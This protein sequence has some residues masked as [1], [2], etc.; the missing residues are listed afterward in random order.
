V[1]KYIRLRAVDQRLSKKDN[2]VRPRVDGGSISP[3]EAQRVPELR[4]NSFKSLEI[5]ASAGATM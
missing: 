1:N 3:P 2:C 5:T 4:R